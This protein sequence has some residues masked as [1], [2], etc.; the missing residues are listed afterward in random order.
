MRRLIVVFFTPSNLPD[1][2]VT[3]GAVACFSYDT[4]ISSIYIADFFQLS[5][6]QMQMKIGCLWL[7]ILLS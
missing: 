5:V 1:I 2:S 3:V 7:L 4:L 6:L